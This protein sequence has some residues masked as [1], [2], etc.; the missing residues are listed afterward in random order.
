MGGTVP[1]VTSVLPS[2][3]SVAGGT[4]VTITGHGFTQATAV[5]F[6]ATPATNF[7]VDS[8]VS[9]TAVLLPQQ[10]TAAWRSR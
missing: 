3:G 5:N 8:D 4:T 9:I 7:T 2:S 10:R 6:G 1:G